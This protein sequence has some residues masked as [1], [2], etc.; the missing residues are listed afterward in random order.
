MTTEIEFKGNIKIDFER[1]LQGVQEKIRNYYS[2]SSLLVT[3]LTKKLSSIDVLYKE[4]C[5]FVE[6]YINE[7]DSYEQILHYGSEDTIEKI[8]TTF[9]DWLVMNKEKFGLHMKAISGDNIIISDVPG[10]EGLPSVL[11]LGDGVYV[12]RM[13]GHSF[14][15]N[16]VE[17]YSEIG[18]RCPFYAEETVHIVN[19][20]QVY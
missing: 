15:Y 17:Y 2:C 16:G 4:F 14:I 11:N 5:K 9:Y 7:Q 13:A 20:K 12:G 18:V 6:F 8:K 1:V 3:E 19:G 10:Y